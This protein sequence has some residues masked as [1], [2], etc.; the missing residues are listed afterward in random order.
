MLAKKLSTV[1]S[2]MSDADV[3]SPQDLL[4]T[5]HDR[6]AYEIEFESLPQDAIEALIRKDVEQISGIF[7]V[8]VRLCPLSC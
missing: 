5:N 1:D 4:A 2:G 6:M 3:D 8:S 7:G